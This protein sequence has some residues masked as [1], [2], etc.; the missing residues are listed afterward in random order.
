MEPPTASPVASPR[1]AVTLLL[2]GLVAGLL[3]GLLGVGGGV[4]MVPLLVGVV[5]FS[6]HSAHATSLAAL[7]AIASVGAAKFALEGSVDFAVAGL[8]AAGALV[9]APLGA[10]LMARAKESTLK[11][12]FGALM[13]VVGAQL[14]WS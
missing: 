11:I 7:I 1:S 4:V 14:L 3:S 2:T 6:Q 5:G 10:G 12:L 13:I 9:G 8:L